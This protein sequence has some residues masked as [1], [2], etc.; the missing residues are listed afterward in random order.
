MD[1]P[2]II[3]LMIRVPIFSSMPH[4]IGGSRVIVFA[5]YKRRVPIILKVINKDKDTDVRKKDIAMAA[6]GFIVNG[7]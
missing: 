2:I 7:A 3:I 6:I 4:G 1:I 5:M